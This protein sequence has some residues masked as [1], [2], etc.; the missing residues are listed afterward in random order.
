[1]DHRQKISSVLHKLLGSDEVYFQPPE[2]KK[3]SY[4]CII[5]TFEGLYTVPADNVK[6]M[7]RPRYNVMHIYRNPD[8]HLRGEFL[9]SFLLVQHDRLYK[10][11]N[12]Y[13]EVYTV[14]I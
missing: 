12:L 7:A 4:P 11:D 9:S 8:E 10:E 5:Y 3:I 2:N 14:Y 6:Y 13:H 1:M